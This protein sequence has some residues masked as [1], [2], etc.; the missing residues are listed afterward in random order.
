MTVTRHRRLALG[1]LAVF[2]A[3]VVALTG[4]TPSSPAPAE[5]AEVVATQADIDAALQVET[6]I[7]FWAWGPQY[8]DEVAAFM[9]E[10]PKVT[11]TLSNQGSNQTEYTKLQNVIAA[12][13]GIPDVAQIEYT[14]LPQFA[15][16]DSLVELGAYGINDMADLYP[17]ATWSQVQVNGGTYGLPQDTGPLAMFYRQDVFDQFGLEVPTTWD[18]YIETA[19]DLR[20]A[21]PTKFIAP[22]SGDAA[23]SN[24]LIWQAGG[25]P[26]SSE[27]TTVGIDLTDEGTTR[28]AE[29]WQQ[30]IDDDLIDT[31]NASF[32]PEWTQGLSSGKYATWITGAWGAG[33][34]QRRL[35]EAAG[36]WR[37]APIPQYEEGDN[38]AGAQGGSSSAILDASENKLA[39][40]GFVQWLSGNSDANQ[41]WA[42]LGGF[43]STVGTFESSFW[44]NREVEY[45]G[46]QQINQ[47]F[48][49]SAANV[50]AGWE[51]LPYQ[52]YADSVFGD[53]VG[54][55]YA[56]RG[57]LLE[58]LAAWQEEQVSYGTTQGFT[59]E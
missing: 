22:D 54:Q 16:G 45:F 57:T 47:V 53:T 56:K 50:L 19:K 38:A 48:A 46:G 9:E 18:E 4:C 24:A 58:G 1:S 41:I 10:Y 5:T 34:L 36:T 30:L 7:T 42:D 11:V 49:D 40:I 28:W 27:G 39:A 12:G 52:A 14:A 29:T 6:E 20:E 17:E 32:S 59:V 35:P 3:S 23:L 37:V 31:A 33:T 25:Q 21:D 43:P 26:Y 51:F 8:A 15:F 44:K 13:S 2:T 55:A